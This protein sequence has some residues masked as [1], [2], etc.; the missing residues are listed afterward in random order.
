[1]LNA[2][3]SVQRLDSSTAL[4]KSEMGSHLKRK[5]PSREHIRSMGSLT[6]ILESLSEEAQIEEDESEGDRT[7]DD[8]AAPA[9]KPEVVSGKELLA[10]ESTEPQ[11][12]KPMPRAA[13]RH[14]TS[15]PKPEASPT[16]VPDGRRPQAAPRHK[17]E[18]SGPQS[19]EPEAKPSP[20]HQKIPELPPRPG[21]PE[22]ETIQSHKHM[23]GST[24]SHATDD[25]SSPS[26]RHKRVPSGSQT[27]EEKA[28]MIPKRAPTDPHIHPPDSKRSPRIP[29]LSPK[30]GNFKEESASPERSLM[31]DKQPMKPT[32]QCSVSQPLL[33][34]PQ[35]PK[36]VRE[37]PEAGGHTV[38][39]S[40]AIPPP[41]L[42]QKHVRHGSKDGV[43]EVKALEHGDSKL[44]ELMGR[45]PSELS[46]R[47]KALLAQ[48]MLEKQKEHAL[49]SVPQKPSKPVHEHDHAMT[50]ETSPVRDRARSFDKLENSPRRIK[51]VL[52]GAINIFGSPMRMRSATVATDEPDARRESIERSEEYYPELPT[53][54]LPREDF[55]PPLPQVKVPP[56]KPPPPLL[57]RPSDEKPLVP[58][59]QH[60]E[61][62]TSILDQ[63]NSSEL[64][65]AADSPTDDVTPTNDSNPLL[66]AAADDPR[67][68][69]PGKLNNDNILG[70]SSDHVAVWL[71]EI[72]LGQYK[73]VFQD[74]GI[75]GVMLFDLDGTR[76][77]VCHMYHHLIDACSDGL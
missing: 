34:N 74:R 25:K 46:V 15:V 4:H 72:G 13:P 10:G 19:H 30:P 3:K 20:P 27:P 55:D 6:D 69:E 64:D 12:P 21:K 73:Q 40:R 71:T 51:K 66:Q 26:P 54:P 36:A 50:N 37:T 70:W 61:T 22:A 8:D 33:A 7:P 52:P 24:D 16:G 17:R 68:P 76:L 32:T 41:R 35:Q 23:P 56:K 43:V 45:D 67:P 14:K 63:I 5:K 60:Y 42:V 65:I 29:D 77:K 62:S 39:P 11:R 53:E 9:A 1:M 38:E 49:P 28:K 31:V 48:K 75:Q 2:V 59:Y 44:E 58:E 57:K 18:H 47:E